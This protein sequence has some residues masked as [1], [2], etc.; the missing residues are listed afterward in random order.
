[1]LIP[2]VPKFGAALAGAADDDASTVPKVEDDV[3]PVLGVFR[4][5]KAP[6]GN[7]PPELAADT[8]APKAGT[9]TEFVDLVG[10]ENPPPPSGGAPPGNIEP[11][12]RGSNA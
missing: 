9:E 2:S 5:S 8:G 1:M 10:K 11:K 4:D 7:T 6:L 12:D 3:V